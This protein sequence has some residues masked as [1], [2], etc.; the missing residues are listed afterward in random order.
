VSTSRTTGPSGSARRARRS[1]P[2]VL[3]PRAD[4]AHLGSGQGAE[5]LRVLAL[6]AD[7]FLRVPHLPGDRA[8][9]C[10]K[11]IDQLSGVDQVGDAPGV[12]Q[13]LEGARLAVLIQV[14]DP[15]AEPVEQHLVLAAEEEKPAR[16]HLVQLGQLG[17]LLPVQLEVA[18]ERREPRRDDADLRGEGAD[19][20]VD[21]G[22]LAGERPLALLRLRDLRLHPL[23]ARV[24]RLLAADDVAARGARRDGYEGREE[25]KQ[26]AK[27]HRA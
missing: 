1:R 11:R 7:S 19:L 25:W 26:A 15:V 4:R 23:E 27:P 3:R 21:R 24:D 22:D 5:A 12:E 16:L 20:A 18:L 13:H 6:P 2:A 17:E 9:L 10:A 8:I 14:H